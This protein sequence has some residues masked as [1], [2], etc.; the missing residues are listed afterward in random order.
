MALDAASWK[1]GLQGDIIVATQLEAWAKLAFGARSELESDP[2]SIQGAPPVPAGP[3][4]TPSSFSCLSPAA[5]WLSVR[6]R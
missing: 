5:T 3:C 6:C 2:R 4:G 1:V